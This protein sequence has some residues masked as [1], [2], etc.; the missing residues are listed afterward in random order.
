VL[1]FLYISICLLAFLGLAI[2]TLWLGVNPT[3]QVLPFGEEWVNL[4]RKDTIK[5]LMLVWLIGPPLLMYIHWG[6]FCRRYDLINLELVQH[7]HSL[8]RNIWLAVLGAI[9]VL[10]GIGAVISS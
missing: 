1:K 8:L 9:V 5:G 4:T 2:Y 6:V 10:F 7:S 3:S